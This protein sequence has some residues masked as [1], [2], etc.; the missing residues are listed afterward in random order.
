MPNIK[1]NISGIFMCYLVK[2]RAEDDPEWVSVGSIGAAG[3]CNLFKMTF[4]EILWSKANKHD[5]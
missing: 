3:M 1:I 5:A 4:M 2:L